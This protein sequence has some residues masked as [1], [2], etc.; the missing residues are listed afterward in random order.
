MAINDL[1]GAGPVAAYAPEL[2]Y[3]GDAPIHTDAGIS[4]TA[5]VKY[6]VAKRTLGTSIGRVANV[7]ADT[8]KDYVIV[9]QPI[10]GAGVETPYFDAGHFN[11]AVLTWPADLNTL[12]KRKA[13]FQGTPIFIG[14]IA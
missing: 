2:L 1:A 7:G 11:H 9:A 4:T 10:T 3:A 12:A 6:E 5:L 14:H 13:F 8:G